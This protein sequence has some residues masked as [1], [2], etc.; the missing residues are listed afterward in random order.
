[1][2]KYRVQYCT[3][4]GNDMVYFD[5]RHVGD[6]Y[7][8]EKWER[9]MLAEREDPGKGFYTPNRE[10]YRWSLLYHAL[11]HKPV[12]SEEY[13]AKLGELFDFPEG[14]YLQ[15]LRNFLAAKNYSITIPDDFSVYANEAN[16]GLRRTAKPPLTLRK[17]LGLP[18]RVYRKLFR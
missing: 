4:V 15:E 13:R 17:V 11:I 5:L 14:E 7:Y 10:N 8:C 2:E 12:V 6:N 3:R 9:D 16:S 1:M 18:K